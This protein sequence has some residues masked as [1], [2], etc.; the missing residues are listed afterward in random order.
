MEK[1]KKYFGFGVF[2]ALPFAL[3]ALIFSCNGGVTPTPALPVAS[4]YTACAPTVANTTFD[5][6][7]WNIENF[8]QRAESTAEVAKIITTTGI[9]LIAF[10][11]VSSANAMENLLA[12]LPGWEGRIAISGNINLGY[13]YKTAEV[14]LTGLTTLYDSLSS[15]FPRPPV[16]TVATHTSGLTAT[17]INIHL[18]CC[19]GADNVSRRTEASRLLKQF[20][21]TNL[22]DEPVIL[23]GDFN[24]E[25]TPGSEGTPFQNF[26]DA[27]ND[28]VFVDMQIALD[29][30]LGWSYPSWPS[31]IDHILITNELFG[32]VL[33]TA[34]LSLE[35]CA[36]GYA[37]IVS[38]HRPVMLRL[39]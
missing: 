10:Q 4:D 30:N 29:E 1:Y 23:L 7:T 26:I 24:D 17:F 12:E 35:K 37:T 31:H 6:L 8:P 25:I 21:D 15:P 14:S 27:G 11:E 3:A 16:V 5:I 36:N 22:P 19:G 33:E 38:D 2:R 18:K 39:E 32:N 34:T 9:D 13:L 20:I 28:Y